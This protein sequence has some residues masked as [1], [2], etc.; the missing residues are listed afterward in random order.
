MGKHPA[1]FSERDE[2]F[3]DDV[4]NTKQS[5]EESFYPNK[6]SVLSILQAYFLFLFFK[7]QSETDKKTVMGIK[8]FGS[9]KEFNHKKYQI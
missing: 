4:E 5:S 9:F 1:F 7:S 2:T 6:I 3:F 8:Y